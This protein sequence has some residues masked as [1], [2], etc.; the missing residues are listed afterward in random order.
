M[1]SQALYA[2]IRHFGR[3]S[4]HL[5]WF[6]VVLPSLTLTYFGRLGHLLKSSQMSGNVFIGLAQNGPRWC[7]HFSR[8]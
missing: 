8:P 7:R 6:F 1:R 4:I 3:K 2:D 5:A